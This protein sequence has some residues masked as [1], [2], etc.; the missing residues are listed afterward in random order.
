[1]VIKSLKTGLLSKTARNRHIIA[2]YAQFPRKMNVIEK[3]G[4][5]AAE[6]RHILSPQGY[7]PGQPIQDSR[8]PSDPSYGPKKPLKTA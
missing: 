3:L 1:L 7:A 6:N 4:K 5:R 8:R 2:I